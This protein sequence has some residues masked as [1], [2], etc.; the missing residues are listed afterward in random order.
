MFV[1]L[2]LALFNLIMLVVMI[3]WWY[4]L[5]KMCVAVIKRLLDS[6]RKRSFKNYIHRMKDLEW[7]KNLNIEIQENDEGKWIEIH[8]NETADDKDD[9][10]VLQ[11][12][13]DE[14]DM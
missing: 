2:Q 6:R 9:D 11:E 1:I 13:P 3:V 14:Q 10:G 5:C 12:D 7:L 4:K 8:L